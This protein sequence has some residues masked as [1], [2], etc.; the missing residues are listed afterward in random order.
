MPQ[1]ITIQGAAER[2]VGI[3]Y[4]V[5]VLQPPIGVGGMGRVMRGVKVDERTGGRQPVAVKF[6][7]DGLPPHVIERAQREAAIRIVSE[8]LVMMHGLVT[9]DVVDAEGTPHTH[10]HVISELLHGVMLHNV[11]QGR[12]TDPD[13]IP[14]P[15]AEELYR[16]SQTDPVRFAVDVVRRLLTGVM[17]LHDH[18]YIHR[19][20]DPSN[21][22]ATSDGTLKIIDFGVALPFR[23]APVAPKAP[24]ASVPCGVP[25]GI[26]APGAP[27][28]PKAPTAAEALAAA[29]AP[30]AAPVLSAEAR[31]SVLSSS[32]FVGKAEYA[33]PE[34]ADCAL[35]QQNASTDIYAL[36]ILLFELA[37]GRRPFTGPI[38]A[39]L[40]QQRTAPLPLDEVPH[41]ALREVVSRATAKDQAQRFQTAPELRVALDNVHRQLQFRPK[42]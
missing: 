40:E 19:D 34:L 14:V 24:A 36:G 6:L 39:V 41:P 4:E 1:V 26:N 18:G 42:I 10:H 37:T 2:A 29:E 33:A 17:T 9:I 13:G 15:Y 38:E 23:A 32:A 27:T 16:L 3:H 12:T 28:A 7:Y 8:N 30:A 31:L 21:I 35:E 5:D 11:L 22:M 25:Q 20:L